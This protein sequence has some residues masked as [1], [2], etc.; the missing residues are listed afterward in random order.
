MDGRLEK[1][2]TVLV[3]ASIFGAGLSTAESGRAH[4]LPYGGG[5]L[6]MGLRRIWTK[7]VCI[8]KII[9]QTAF[10]LIRGMRER[11]SGIGGRMVSGRS[12]YFKDM[13]ETCL[14]RSVL[15]NA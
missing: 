13:R 5:C 3:E 14:L 9:L 7:K 1:K 15:G 4:C 2:I 12:M 6:S 11:D 8:S 10:A